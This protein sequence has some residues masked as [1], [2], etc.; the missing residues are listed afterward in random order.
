MAKKDLSAALDLVMQRSEI[1]Y[2]NI[3]NIVA[4]LTRLGFDQKTAKM[5]VMM[6]FQDNPDVKYL[7]SAGVTALQAAKSM[8]AVNIDLG[9]ILDDLIEMGFTKDEA[10]HAIDMINT[11][12]G[13]QTITDHTNTDGDKDNAFAGVD[14]PGY[15]YDDVPAEAIQ[16][17]L[18]IAEENRDEVTPDSVRKIL[19]KYDVSSQSIDQLTQDLLGRTSSTKTALVEL[20][21]RDVGLK[22]LDNGISEEQV[23]N[24]LKRQGA[25][26]EEAQAAALPREGG[27]ALDNMGDPE[28]PF[29]AKSDDPED[30]E[31]GPSGDFPYSAG[32]DTEGP[33]GLND[34]LE[35]TSYDSTQGA[36]SGFMDA[37]KGDQFFNEAQDSGQAPDEGSGNEG[38]WTGQG[39]K[40]VSNDPQMTRT[41]LKQI[42]NN[43]GASDEEAKKVTDELRL[44][45][46][47]A[48]NP[49]T[50]VRAGGTL[51]EITGLWDTLYGKMASVRMESGGEYE[52]AIEDIAPVGQDKL[53]VTRDEIFDK[54]A[55]HLSGDWYDGLETLPS[56]YRDTYSDR[57]NK[58]R[59]LQSEV[60]N[61]LATTKDIGEMGLLG[62]ARSA[63]AN[64]I[65]FCQTRLASADFVGEEEYVN[66]LPKYEFAK[67]ASLGY[68]F[69]PG[70]GESM[71]LI[72]EE[73]EREAA[74]ID[75]NELSRTASV[76]FVGD[77]SPILIGDGQEVARLASAFIS[78]KVAALPASKAQEVASDFLA[79]V[80]K[81]R[82][83]MVIQMR[84]AGSLSDYL[85]PQEQ[86]DQEIVEY[87]KQLDALFKEYDEIDDAIERI[88]DYAE[89]YDDGHSDD[90]RNAE[91]IHEQNR[92]EVSKHDVSMEIANTRLKIDELKDKRPE[93]ESSQHAQQNEELDIVR[94]REEP[95]DDNQLYNSVH[96]SSKAAEE[97]PEKKDDC[98]NCDCAEVGSHCATCGWDKGD[99]EYPRN[100]KYYGSTKDENLFEVI[101]ELDDLQDEVEKDEEDKKKKKKSSTEDMWDQDKW[102]VAN[103]K[104][105]KISDE[106]WLV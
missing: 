87:Q 81:V 66:S 73:M 103:T 96:G 17:I 37:S 45:D 15:E 29:G 50:I 59:K 71:V 104:N 16:E 23:V 94:S 47:P 101:D 91:I 12:E 4:E 7:K 33:G 74:A 11:D 38:Y 19:D 27:P 24:E 56:D 21:W 26:D 48:I 65:V 3:G 46:D 105:D 61:R 68:G 22:M 106:G 8:F 54:V 5:A 55:T 20:A 18:D 6:A 52:F 28:G 57:M 102:R 80:E 42:L 13:S 82:R 2:S 78:D 70:G 88:G 58:A 90:P 25:S 97:E 67:E 9:T 53:A 100:N 49:G 75:W 64:E 35:G 51:G 63:L 62:E 95:Y 41:D 10:S 77:L 30:L 31:M 84:T 85:F 83:S 39:E 32:M 1:K 86:I 44:E 89:P 93:N 99:K 79:N 60:N 14:D 92:L 69:G 72:A 34:S 40:Y 36:G 76:E 98:P 43:E